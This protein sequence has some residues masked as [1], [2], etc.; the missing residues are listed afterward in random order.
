MR[1][2]NGLLLGVVVILALSMFVVVGCGGSEEEA[3]AELSAALDELETSIAGFQQMGADS[4]VDDIIAARDAVKEDWAAVAEA[5]K[6]VDEATTSEAEQAWAEADAAIDSVPRDASLVEA[7]V[8]IL[9]PVQA[10]LTEVNNLRAL[11]PKEE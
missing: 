6:K 5:G 1:L 9:P 3:K 11:V 7:A 10:F 2:R 4:T 8:I